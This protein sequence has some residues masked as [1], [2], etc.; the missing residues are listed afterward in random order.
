M[1]GKQVPDV[2]L[3]AVCQVHGVTH[4]PTYNIQHFARPAGLVPGLTVVRPS[5][6]SAVYMP[7]ISGEMLFGVI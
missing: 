5:D 1:I 3:I 4:V 7:W 6:V 2:R